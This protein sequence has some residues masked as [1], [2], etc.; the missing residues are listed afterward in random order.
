M[1]TC[2]TLF[3]ACCLTVPDKC[4]ICCSF[5]PW[6]PL[7]PLWIVRVRFNWLSCL[8][9]AFDWCLGSGMGGWGKKP[10]GSRA[11]L[12]VLL[13]TCEPAEPLT[14]E[15]GNC[16]P[17][18]SQSRRKLS[19]LILAISTSFHPSPVFLFRLCIKYGHLSQE[20][21]QKPELKIHT[22]L[23]FEEGVQSIPP[24]SIFL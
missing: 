15:P 8:V 21:T 22:S 18:F 1:F 16:Q 24:F 4:L 17:S 9:P 11:R 2:L 20:R 7:L 14:A 23:A 12:A 6:T 19:S 10:D 5:F 13:G 3:H